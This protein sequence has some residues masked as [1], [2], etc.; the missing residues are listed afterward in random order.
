L[1]IEPFTFLLQASA[2]QRDLAVGEA[3]FHQGDR[4]TAIFAV[5]TG[6]IK[7]VRYLSSGAEVCLQ[8]ARVK[9]TF[10]EAAL[11]SETYH[12]D[13]IADLPSQVAIYSKAEFLK[14]FQADP[15]L[16]LA[17]TQRLTK[18]IQALRTQVELRN[19][20]S[21]YERVL[22]HLLLMVEPG[23]TTIC[24]DRPLKDA[25]RDIGLTH[26]VFYRT[27]AQLEQAG[28]ISRHR[29]TIKLRLLET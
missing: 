19:I 9:D 11:F 20:H 18:Q 22:Q 4:A 21:A 5:E 26:E 8:V 6:R 25:A 10:A 28:A 3:L 13:A 15:E 7:L 24:F 17:F 1:T 27:L 29:R 16:A 14:L 2:T 23:Q 12:C